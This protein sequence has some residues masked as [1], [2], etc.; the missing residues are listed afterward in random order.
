MSHAN[1]GVI[2]MVLST[3]AFSVM[4]AGVRH[5]SPDLHPF[6]TVFLRNLFGFMV[7]LPVIL[8]HGAGFLK[9]ARLPVHGLRALLNVVAMAAFFASLG[10]T[11]LARVTALSFTAP[12][13]TAILS[14]LILGETFR[15]RRW[16]A[17]VF[18][19]LGTLIILRPG[20]ADIDLGSLFALLAASIWGVTMIVIK[21]LGRTESSLTITGYMNL[22]LCALSIIPAIL[23]WQW[24]KP[25]IWMWLVF[26]GISGTLA[27][28]ALAQA[29]K[30][31][32][33]T[34][35]MSFDFLKLVWA[36]VLG[37]L[38]FFEIPDNFIWLGA[39]IIFSSGVYIAYR[40]R[41]AKTPE[42]RS[43]P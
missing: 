30:E 14:V 13:F 20:I 29:L 34:I 12:I 10:L 36:S 42:V 1:R 32:E 43:T 28:L 24:P 16:T 31:T 33:T 40:E 23:V 3:I 18:G 19:F 27:Q 35:V 25:E 4:H 9:T 2:F 39:A 41:G 5:V 8:R 11:P 26:I 22:L 15:I 37:Y 38:F 21:I 6:Q 7:F 17:I